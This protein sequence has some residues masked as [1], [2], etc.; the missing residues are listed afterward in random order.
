[1]SKKKNTER[2][3]VKSII[4]KSKSLFGK[5]QMD[6]AIEKYTNEG[7]I[8]ADKK[9]VRNQDKYTLEFHY[10]MSQEEIAK[11]D[12]FKRN[13][14]I[15]LG[16]LMFLCCGVSYFQGEAAQRQQEADESTQVAINNTE[17]AHATQTATLWT[18]TP[19]FTP[20][21]TSTPSLTPTLT[22]TPTITLTPTQTVTPSITPSPTITNTLRPTNTDRPTSLPRGNTYYSEGNNINVRSCP[23]LSCEVVDVLTFAEEIEIIDSS[24]H[25][26][27]VSGDTRWMQA[28]VNGELAYVHSSLVSSTRPRI[29]TA[30]PQAVVPNTTTNTTTNTNNASSQS[31]A[32]PPPQ[33][34]ASVCSC[35]ADTYN[36]SDF[37]R[38][39]EAQACHN[40]CQS[41]RGYDVHGLDGNDN[42]G[43][44][45]ESLP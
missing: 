10:I 32:P 1:M 20:T 25:G 6:K 21:L 27:A 23:E 14:N 17:S 7:W 36:C 15:I 19:T 42:D 11:E 41:E 9:K 24:Y 44:A 28:V 31:V 40:Q 16:V 12:R 37:N 4:A 26:D 29:V 22:L 3:K 35:N 43:L 38:Q 18:L 30:V 34:P 13:R 39:S 8:L 33:Q 45:C 5:T 2:I